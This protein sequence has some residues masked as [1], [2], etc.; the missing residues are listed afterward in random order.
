MAQRILAE[1]SFV[2]SVTYTLPNK[3]YVP[4]DMRYI[5]VDNLT[6][7]DFSILPFLQELTQHK[8]SSKAE[9]FMPLA[10][11]RWVSVPRTRILADA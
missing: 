5:S 2:Q 7:Y 9:V 1:N 8:N 6:P 10:A 4:V 11:P 3:H